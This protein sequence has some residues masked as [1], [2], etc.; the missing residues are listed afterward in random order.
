MK[1][2]FVYILKCADGTYYTDFTSN[3]DAK[4]ES[5]KAGKRKDT[6][7]FE[8][9]PVHLVF[10]SEFTVPALA[11]AAKRKINRWSSDKKEALINGEFQKLM[12]V[13]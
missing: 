10:E 12:Q 7:T 2:Y 13:S 5:H 9:R 4:L 1:T 8:R 3:L 11:I 6:Y